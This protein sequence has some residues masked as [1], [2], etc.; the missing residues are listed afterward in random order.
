MDWNGSSLGWTVDDPQLRSILWMRPGPDLRDAAIIVRAHPI[1]HL[2]E[3]L[4]FV[5]LRFGKALV[6][7]VGNRQQLAD[8]DARQRLE[9]FRVGDDVHSAADE[10]VTDHLTRDGVVDHFIHADLVRPRAT[11]QEEIVQQVELEIAAREYVAAVPWIPVRIH[12]QSRL[13]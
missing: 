7:D 2:V 6:A 13:P 11:L 8:V 5:L 4:R 3:P 9:C 12:W 10:K 1:H